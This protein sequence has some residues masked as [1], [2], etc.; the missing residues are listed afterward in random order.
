MSSFSPINV[1]KDSSLFKGTGKLSL[2]LLTMQFTISLTALVMGIVFARNAEFQKTVDLGYARDEL[3]VLRIA[4]ELF[5]SFKNEISTNPKIISTGGTQ[6]H[7]GFGNYRRPVKDNEKQLEVDVLDIGPHMLR[8]WDSGLPKAAFLMRTRLAADRSNSSIVVNRKFVNDFGWKEAVG[9]TITLYDT[10]KLT[11][12]GVVEDF[13]LYG[14]WQ[15]I[16]PVML[17]LSQTDQY[18]VLAVQLQT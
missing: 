4:P 7:I 17:R 14:V 13:Y 9:K 2:V 18:D 3:I 6:N 12:I 8:Q 10:T 15:A 11:I 1:L 5:T 16:E